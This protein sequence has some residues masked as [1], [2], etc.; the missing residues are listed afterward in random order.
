MVAIQQSLTANSSKNH[1][2]LVDARRDLNQIADLIELCFSETIDPD[3]ES[4]LQQMRKAARNTSYLQWAG[5]L[6]EQAP[7]PT[8]GFVWEDDGRIIGNLT[9]IPTLQRANPIYLIANVAV[10]PNYRRQGIARQLTQAALD[11]ARQRR[12]DSIWLHVR[13]ENL[14]AYQLYRSLGFIER[15]RRVTWFYSWEPNLSVE[16]LSNR[17]RSFTRPA[18]TWRQ[19]SDWLAQE[20]W[21][22]KTYPTELRWHLAIK[23]SLMKPGF[24]SWLYRMFIDARVEHW[25][26]RYRD[27][28]MGVITWQPTSNYADHLWLAVKPD[29]EDIATY[30]LLNHIVGKFKHKRPLSLDYPAG[31]AT[32]AIQS[33]GFQLHQTLVWMN[34][35]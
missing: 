16:P 3:G 32:N 1:L 23:S 11:Y 33:A 25:C 26:A 15:A 14:G 4:Y 22:E 10:H 19:P 24:L 30:T 13:E 7:F 28:L 9:L 2:R 21:L 31:R 18:I 5:S 20:N 27:Q 8:S 6:G 12:A 34:I 29:N 17:L 35:V